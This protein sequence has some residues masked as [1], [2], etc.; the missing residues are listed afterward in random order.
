MHI[1]INIFRGN[2]MVC[3]CITGQDISMHCSI[4]YIL[5]TLPNRFGGTDVLCKLTPCTDLPICQTGVHAW[6]FQEEK[7]LR[8]LWNPP[9]ACRQNEKVLEL[10]N[11]LFKQHLRTHMCIYVKTKFIL[12]HMGTETELI[13]ILADIRARRILWKKV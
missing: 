10:R 3:S 7:F 9:G 6:T 8:V 5:I 12:L 1:H 11:T 13:N 4:F 2:H